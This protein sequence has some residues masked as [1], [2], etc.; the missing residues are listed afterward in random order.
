[1]ARIEERLNKKL[2]KVI[3]RIERFG[4]SEKGNPLSIMAKL[5]KICEKWTSTDSR[6]QLLKISHTMTSFTRHVDMNADACVSLD[7]E[8]YNF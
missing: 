4:V 1:M 3:Y 8:I 2:N 6:T 5:N 7:G